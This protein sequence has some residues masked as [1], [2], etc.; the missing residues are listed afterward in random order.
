MNRKIMVGL[1]GIAAV[2]ALSGCAGEEKVTVFQVSV[3]GKTVDCVEWTWVDSD[4]TIEEV[5]LA[6]DFAGATK[7]GPAK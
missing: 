6:C 3:N 4:N 7:A 1:V 5:A 2:F